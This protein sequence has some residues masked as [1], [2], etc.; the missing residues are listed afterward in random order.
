MTKFYIEIMKEMTYI[1]NRINGC[2]G[3]YINA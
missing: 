2:Y 3:F 1:N